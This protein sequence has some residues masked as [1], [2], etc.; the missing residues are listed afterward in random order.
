M[1]WNRLYFTLPTP[2]GPVEENEVR[3]RGSSAI[4]G[5]SRLESHG[6]HENVNTR[7]SPSLS[8]P[9][10]RCA[11]RAHCSTGT[12][13]ALTLR[14]STSLI[15]KAISVRMAGLL[16]PGQFR[17][18]IGWH[19]FEHFYVRVPRAGSGSSTLAAKSAHR[20]E[21][22]TRE[23]RFD[24]HR[25]GPRCLL[26]VSRVDRLHAR[27]LRQTSCRFNQRDGKH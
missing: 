4:R 13:P 3:D 17:P 10:G 23:E 26:V 25:L 6:H 15:I 27:H 8:S 11:L 2:G 12:S 22:E 21:G 9:S 5:S 19:Q 24:F 7:L 1:K 14:P 18:N 16:R 20:S